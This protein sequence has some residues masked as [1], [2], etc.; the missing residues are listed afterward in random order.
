MPTENGRSRQRSL[1]I[2]IPVDDWLQSLAAKNPS[3]R[4][5]QVAT[6]AN[7]ILEREFTKAQRKK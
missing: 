6:E 1:R 3:N 4:Y 2:R 7:V 5:D